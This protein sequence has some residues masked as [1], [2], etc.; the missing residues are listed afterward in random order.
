MRCGSLACPVGAEDTFK[1]EGCLIWLPYSNRLSEKPNSCI[2]I[3]TSSVRPASRPHSPV[4]PGCREAADWKS[5]IQQ[6]GNVGNLR[7]FSGTGIC[8][9]NH[10]PNHLDACPGF[11][12]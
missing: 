3:I 7:Y 12:H 9:R 5:A 11:L 8:H 1:S 4:R 2:H 10:I 6:V